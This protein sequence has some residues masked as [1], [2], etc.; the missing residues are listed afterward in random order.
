MKKLFT[1]TFFLILFISFS[2]SGS[3]QSLRHF[4]IS[5]S[6]TL[7]FIHGSAKRSKNHQWGHQ[8]AAGLSWSKSDR[9]SVQAGL[10]YSF[11]QAQYYYKIDFT[12]EVLESWYR[13]Q[14]LIIPLH[15]KYAF[16]TKPNRGYVVLGLMPSFKLNRKLIETRTSGSFSWTKDATREQYYDLFDIPLSIG[17]GYSL[18][19]KN[20]GHFYLQPSYRT[21]IATQ[22]YYLLRYLFGRRNDTNDSPPV[23]SS[24]GITAGFA[25]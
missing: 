25:W 24:Y 17:A 10:G 18:S 5:Y 8:V 19:Y 9:F 13:H 2:N 15:L 23:W 16:S 1:I 12:G 14:D 7:M 22:F 21:N 11:L 6:P 3:A 20:V 4:D